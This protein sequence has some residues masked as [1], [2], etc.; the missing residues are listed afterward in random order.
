VAG[1]TGDVPVVGVAAASMR[2]T[3]ERVGGSWN[4]V[5]CARHGP[6]F[7]LEITRRGWS[8][9]GGVTD[10]GQIALRT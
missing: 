9:P 7:D 8:H 3:R 4:L 1:P 2:A 10:L 5:R 6:G